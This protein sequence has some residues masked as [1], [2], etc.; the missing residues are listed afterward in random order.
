MFHADGQ[1]PQE[2]KLDDPWLAE[3]GLFV[4]RGMTSG[5]VLKAFFLWREQG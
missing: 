5:G 4:C 3:A 2:I 1:S